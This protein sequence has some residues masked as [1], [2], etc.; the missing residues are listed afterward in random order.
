MKQTVT[1]SF[2]SVKEDAAGQSHDFIFVAP[3]YAPIEVSLEALKEIHAML[4]ENLT[5][6]LARQAQEPCDRVIEAQPVDQAT[7]ETDV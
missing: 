6:S 5:Q 4:E 1:V 7:G 2:Q 3:Y